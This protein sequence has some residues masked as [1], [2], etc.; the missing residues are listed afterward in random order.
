MQK[1]KKNKYTI[2]LLKN[3]KIVQ[4]NCIKIVTNYYHYH[5][6]LVGCSARRAD[7]RVLI[8]LQQNLTNTCSRSN[9]CENIYETRYRPTRIETNHR[10]ASYRMFTVF[11]TQEYRT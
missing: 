6:C 9:V 8:L 1:K 5:V 7:I 3:L 10:G 11:I 2:L 4:Y